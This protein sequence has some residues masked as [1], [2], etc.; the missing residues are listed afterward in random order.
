[1][2]SSI[3]SLVLD[4][5]ARREHFP[6]CKNSVFLAHA[7]VNVLPRVVADAVIEYTRRS[8][9]QHQEFGD[10]M[11]DINDTRRIAGEFIGAQPDEIALLGPTSLGL[12]L[13]ANGL[14]WREGD[15]ILCYADD[16]PANVYPWMELARRGV[17]VRRLE[18]ERP[19]EITPEL[20][21]ASITP[22]TR[23]A[24]LA[25]CNFLT[26]CRI[27]VDAIGKIL[28]ERGVLFSLDAIQTLGA[29]P[30]SVGHVDFLSADAHKWML[31]PLAIG[32]VFVKKEHFDLL[33]PT[34]LGAW[35][36]R[37]PNFIAQ[38]DIR[39]F[40]TAQ[41]YEPGVL[42][43][44]G[45]YGMKAALEMLMAV[46]IEKVSG[47]ILGLKKHLVDALEALGFEFIA[48][49]SGPNT[50]GITTFSHPSAKMS[51][52][53]RRLEE[54]QIIASLR[55]DRE[56]RQY[57]RLSP[58]F[59]NTIEE[60]DRTIAVLKSGL[61]GKGN[62]EGTAQWRISKSAPCLRLKEPFSQS[63]WRYSMESIQLGHEILA[64]R[65]LP[66]CGGKIE[67]LR[68]IKS[69]R[70]W[71]WR[72][73]YLPMR[74]PAYGES[75]IEKLDFGGWDEIFPSVSPCNLTLEN[76]ETISIPDHGDLVSLPWTVEKRDSNS[77]RLSCVGRS[78]PFRFERRIALAGDGFTATYSLKN[79]HPNQSLP[80]LWCAHPLIAI[81]PGMAIRWT[82]I[83]G[84][85]A[86]SSTVPD[87]SV[88][89]FT[90]S[91]QKRFVTGAAEVSI[92]DPSGAESLRFAFRPDQIPVLGFWIN[93]LGWTGSSTPNLFNLGVEPAT[94]AFDG[95]D[96]AIAVN[97]HRILGANESCE[98][99]LEVSLHS[100]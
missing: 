26:G 56:N 95:L 47:R 14:P 67:S 43:V 16:Y 86:G 94:A 78:W 32:I 31:G 29:Q 8:C 45:I 4:E 83:D 39:F 55:F 40:D 34:L 97:Q 38:P 15:E 5:A 48:P 54:N 27:D 52:L 49:T 25:S 68:S 57:L 28:H 72:N 35:N 75:Y 51:D 13:F 62:D 59:Y 76:G 50:S 64:I 89:G 71:L 88:S 66:E 24:A 9:E 41:R 33:R 20:V 82:G 23:L 98:W 81:E 19:G 79:N 46:G 6:V 93:Y 10:V 61:C 60:L 90:P 87:P 73:P 53:F 80:W 70:E 91:A 85:E 65:I 30:L 77:A 92:A 100:A 2:R 63:N 12:S 11:R 18:P 22:R 99:S 37:S 84:R 42:N 3:D 58:H 1:M 17:V 69:G 7:G 21:A 74:R 36:V 96:E 44:A